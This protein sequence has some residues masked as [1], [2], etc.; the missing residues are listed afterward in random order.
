MSFFIVP[1]ALQKRTFIFHFPKVKIKEA[2]LKKQLDYML[3]T[4]DLRP[5]QAIFAQ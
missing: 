2:F 3:F 1:M 5:K 4:L